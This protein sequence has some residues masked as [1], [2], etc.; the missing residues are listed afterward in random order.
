[1]K[2]NASKL[3]ENP[4]E[5]LTPEDKQQFLIQSET[6]IIR[7]STNLSKYGRK[8]SGAFAGFTLD[9]Y[10]RNH[11]IKNLYPVSNA[12]QVCKALTLREDHDK[13]YQPV[14]PNNACYV[15]TKAQ[16][17]YRTTHIVHPVGTQMPRHQ[18]VERKPRFNAAV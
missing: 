17:A 7:S 13:G 2:N 14:L 6:L 15:F 4:N 1:M 8:G 11:G 18:F 16:Q 12:T 3:L 9:I 10:S 5:W